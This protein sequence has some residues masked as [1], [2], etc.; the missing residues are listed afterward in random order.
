MIFHRLCVFFYK[1][2]IAAKILFRDAQ[3]YAGA[4]LGCLTRR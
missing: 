2:L 3:F 4:G 1:R